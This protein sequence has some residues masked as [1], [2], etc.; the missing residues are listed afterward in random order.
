M[1]T[2]LV[3]A[4]W[5]HAHL[6]E[7]VLKVVD[8]SWYLPDQKRDAAAEF[9]TGH[10][11][12]A[13]RF[14]IDEIADKASGLP[15][16]LPD[17]AAFAAAAGALGLSDTDTIVVYD[18][19]G[20]F[21][22]ARVWWMLK[23]FGAKDVRVLDG[24][25]PAWKAAGH[26]LEAGAASPVP[27]TFDARLDA[28]AVADFASVGAALDD[29]SATIVD[30]RSAPRFR[31]EAPEPRPGVRAGHMPGARNVHYASLLDAAGRLRPPEEN[32][33]AFQSAGVDLS[34]PVITSCG[35]GVTAAILLL[36]LSEMGKADVRIYDG[37]WSE[38]GART[39][40][41]VVT[42]PA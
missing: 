19:A 38:W 12:G 11:P 16:M 40:A 26:P 21:S 22:A 15:H 29:A 34:Q 20:L 10:I 30:A 27:A 1:S 18:G 5:L 8:A 28:A 6:G 24:G 9:L 39:D 7:P 4:D 33:Q 35:S 25:L 36:A 2:A 42:G 23:I 41:P 14:D 32:R 3:S 31:G 17:A 37:S 13:V